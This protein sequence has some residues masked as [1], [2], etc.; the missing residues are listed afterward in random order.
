MQQPGEAKDPVATLRGLPPLAWRRR[1]LEYRK[2][3]VLSAL[4]LLSAFIGLGN[5]LYLFAARERCSGRVVS[6]N[7]L[8]GYDGNLFQAKVEYST[9]RGDVFDVESTPQVAPPRVGERRV[10][11]YFPNEPRRADAGTS[12]DALVWALVCCGLALLC[13]GKMNRGHWGNF[14]V[15]SVLLLWFWSTAEA[16]MFQRDRVAAEKYQANKPTLGKP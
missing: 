2:L 3:H 15:C 6:V 8:S 10:V 13:T 7:V 1:L 16:Q 12:T 14:A 4:L 5:A 9:R 11:S